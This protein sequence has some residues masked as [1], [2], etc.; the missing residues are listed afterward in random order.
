MVNFLR[1][2]HAPDCF[3]H[4]CIKRHA[5]QNVSS[6]P[7]KRGLRLFCRKVRKE[8]KKKKG[9]L[10]CLRSE[11]NLE[12]QKEKI[13][14]LIVHSKHPSECLESLLLAG[15]PKCRYLRLDGTGPGP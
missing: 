11:M 8:T 3:P 13:S 15:L 5:N 14:P 12:N 7:Q 6:V 9:K 10:S 2:T 1:P 4:V